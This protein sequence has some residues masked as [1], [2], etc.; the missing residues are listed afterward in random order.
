VKWLIIPILIFFVW[1]GCDAQLK[2]GIPSGKD[3]YIEIANQQA[4]I[5]KSKQI[6]NK[7]G[8]TMLKENTNF[9]IMRYQSWSPDTVQFE[10]GVIAQIGRLC[11]LGICKRITE[12]SVEFE[13]SGRDYYVFR[14]G[15]MVNDCQIKKETIKKEEKKDESKSISNIN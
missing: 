4:E 14:N 8:E 5:R 7:G 6:E 2:T 1:R 10:N 15:L 11:S 13:S 12:N 3:K 9:S